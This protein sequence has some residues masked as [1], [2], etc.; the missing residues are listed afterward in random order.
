MF[1]AERKYIPARKGEYPST[2]CDTSLAK[3]KLG[4]VPVNNLEEYIKSVI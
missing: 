2:L 3:E 1:G 4:W